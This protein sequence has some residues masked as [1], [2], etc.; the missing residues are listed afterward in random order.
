M[1][2]NGEKIITCGIKDYNIK[3]FTW[4]LIDVCNQKCA[5]CNEGFG[6]DEFRPKSSFFKNQSQIDSYK[7]VLKIL[8]LKFIGPFEVDIIGGEPTLH[9]HIYSIIEQINSIDNCKQ[10]SLLTNL[11]K[12]FSFYEK[13]N[14]IAYNKLLFC[15][16]IHFDYYTPEL[17]KKC[18]EINKFK[19]TKIIP[20][21]MLHDDK[22][23]WDNMENFITALIKHNV[24][25]TISFINS[26]FEY[27]TNYTSE[28]YSRFNK[29][30]VVDANKY[31][32]NDNLLLNKYD[33]HLNKLNAFKG[34]KCKPLRYII[35]HTGEIIN[36]CTDKQMSF[37]NSEQFAICPKT[38]CDCDI[39]W[40]YEKYNC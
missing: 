15:P 12:P 29:F 34:W 9:P 8:K 23:H 14:S 38:E 6:S 33:I 18:V 19:H 21:V 24:E 30:I 22:K 26:C 16:S 25:Y 36:A 4:K 28:F 10:I 40:N 11:K 27:T 17:L 32:F 39:Q 5:Y 2:Y 3:T 31:L 37:V 1:T 20:I 7:N 35:K 13:F